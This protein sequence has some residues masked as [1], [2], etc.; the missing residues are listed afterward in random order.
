MT[1][2]LSAFASPVSAESEN[3]VL[4]RPYTVS[5]DLPN[6]KS[7]AEMDVDDGKMLTDGKK[8]SCSWSDPKWAKYYRAGGRIV[9]FDL[10]ALCEV[11]RICT[12]FISDNPAGCYIPEQIDV[13]VSADGE[14]FS[15]ANVK[16]GNVAPFGSSV[17]NKCTIVPYDMPVEAICGR[18]VA[19]HFDVNVNTFI[20][21]VEIYGKRETSLTPP[22]EYTDILP[23]S[24]G[25]YLS[26]D[27]LDGDHD[28]ILFH[29]GYYPDDMSLVN[30]DEKTFLPFLAY[31]D[32]NGNIVDTMFDSVMFLIMQGKCYSDGSLTIS[33]G[34][35]VL[36][37][38]MMLL[39]AYFSDTYNLRALNNT[40]HTIADALGKEDYTIPVYL[41]CPYPKT[42]KLVFGDYNGDGKDETISTYE[43]AL[44][45]TKWFVDECIRR[46][47]ENGY[48]KLKLK[49]F[50]CNSEGLGN[51]RFPYERQYA[52]DC[53]T[54]MH[55]RGLKYVMIPYYQGKGCEDPE[56]YGFDAVL[57]Q[58]NLSFYESL[59]DDPAGMMEDF[60]AA[61]KQFGLG[62]EMEVNSSLIWDIDKHAPFYLQ[63]LQSASQSGLM[64][65][66]IHAYYNG[67]GMAVFGRA[68]YSK[69]P[70]MRLL[71]DLTYKFIKGTLSLPDQ[72]V[73]QG[74]PETL[75]VDAGGKVSGDIELS[76]DWQVELKI[77]KQALHGVVILSDDGKRFT[78]KADRKYSGEDSFDYELTVYG[79]PVASGTV[80]VNILS[81]E[82]AETS[83]ETPSAPVSDDASEASG[84]NRDTPWG[85][86]AAIGGAV[87]LAAGTALAVIR[88]KK[89]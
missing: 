17:Q 58:P 50:F 41:T 57:M 86:F 71:Y 56:A 65:D 76:G 53:C 54:L 89:K 7:Y 33:G 23:K 72:I 61:A 44:A 1:I 9:T 46:F 59:Q 43:D 10:G 51:T 69:E 30:N 63:Y 68:A 5:S 60:D 13:Y 36:G 73:L 48:D 20:D 12:E 22:T 2:G 15:K 42:G 35:T 8:G 39:D 64:T 24:K 29:A 47:E 82:P 80:A 77:A 32:E 62:I 70:K 52:K 26:R 78:F 19:L 55:D 34:E 67:A 85:L 83:S 4:G 14:H 18:Y 31:L 28:I 16:S 79:K 3:L 40:A 6:E 27:A 88:K 21:E 25:A 87:L 38:W 81:D 74:F 11:E 75:T 66:T 45:V 84:A 37:D 49:G